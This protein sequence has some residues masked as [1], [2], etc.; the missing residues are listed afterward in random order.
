VLT[1][2][3]WKSSTAQAEPSEKY[4]FFLHNRFLETNQLDAIH[5]EYGRVE[6]NEILQKFRNNDFTVVSEKRTSNVNALDYAETIHQQIDSLFNKGVLPNHI[7]VVGTS[8]G[9]YIAQYVSTI[10]NNPELNFVFIGSFRKSDM[11]QIPDINFCGNILNIYEKSDPAGVSAVSRKDTSSCEINH[12]KDVE[13]NTGL[14]H[15]FLFK[16]LDVWMQPAMDWAH[17]KY[18]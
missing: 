16:A 3:S 14:R 2:L 8:K 1:L 12:Y 9:G 7:T 15:G 4:I 18:E 5:P 6:Y 13:L 10:A 17:G 11:V